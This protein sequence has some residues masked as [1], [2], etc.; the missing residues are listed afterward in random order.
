MANLLISC[1]K[2]FSNKFLNCQLHIEAGS[3]TNK[4]MQF[5]EIPGLTEYKARLVQAV[6][7]NHL[8]HAQL[9]LG[10]EGSGNLA[11]ALALATFL[12]CNNRLPDDSCGTC[13]S[14]QKNAKFIHP[15]VHYVF[16][17][18]STAKVAGKDV[19]SAAFMKEW[20]AFLS[21]HPYGSI[22]DW[23]Q[24]YG[25]ENKQ[26]NISKAESKHIIQTLSL[27]S[28]E[29]SFKVML[30]WLPENMHPSA[31]NGILK[32]LE[33]PAPR[34][35]FLLVSHD[36][37]R[38]LTTILSRTQRLEVPAFSNEDIKQELGQRLLLDTDKAAYLA[39]LAHGNMNLAFH[40]SQDIVDDS[41]E[42]FSDWM[43]LCY[44]KDYLQL[45]AWSD[46]FHS[47]TKIWQK[48]FLQYGLN[49]LRE[50][51]I[52]HYAN[53]NLNRMAGAEIDFVK[54][55]S[56]VMTPPKLE[57]VAEHLNQ[58][59]YHLERNASPKILFLDLSLQISKVIR[60]NEN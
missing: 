23:G 2:L 15:D 60:T 4:E 22:Q 27:K 47:G 16:P 48:S 3:R 19:S 45:V 57:K 12:N 34:T 36:S 54:K 21:E 56:Q 8:A 58:A 44:G 49:L 20:R 28:F 33:E 25:G 7:N 13:A 42:M 9:F 40:L 43:R 1:K 59:A 26:V 53:S 41:H 18:S 35:V 39:K 52:V 30:I 31:A 6:N 51:L 37:E 10:P 55:F 17:V 50:T 29:G 14:C 46:R 32:I 24:S 11:L 38:L 5:S